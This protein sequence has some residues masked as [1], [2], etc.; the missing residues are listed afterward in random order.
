[1]GLQKTGTSSIQGMFNMAKTTLG[2]NGFYYPD[3]PI[4][5]DHSKVWTSPYRHNIIAGVY[6]DFMSAFEKMDPNEEDVFWAELQNNPL[7]PILSAEEFSR[8]RNHTK[9]GKR[10]EPFDVHVVIYLRRQDRF[11]ESLFNQRNKLLIEKCD[12]RILDDDSLTEQALFRFIKNENYTMV[13][14]FK[15]LLENVELQIKPTKITVRTFDREQMVGGDVCRDI[16]DTLG[17]PLECFTDTPPEANGSVP[18]EVIMKLIEAKNTIGLSG[19][20][21]AL[22][23]A[24]DNM[25][26]N[27]AQKGSYKILSDKTRAELLRQ[28]REIN[29]FVKTKYG[30][31]LS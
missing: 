29:D 4:S 7:C 22:R 9:L 8:Q 6:A 3:L 17:L 2:Q 12:D 14:N 1:M 16:W 11:A 25:R 5:K 23:A 10:L 27:P 31:S 26:S 28:Y 15:R 13:M 30:V 20:R 21:D 24:S 18:N 19:A